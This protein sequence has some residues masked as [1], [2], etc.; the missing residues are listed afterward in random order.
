M[1]PA[2]PGVSP[3]IQEDARLAPRALGEA[4]QD[5]SDIR[6]LEVRVS[7]LATDVH[8]MS[9]ALARNRQRTEQ[10][11]V[12]DEINDSMGASLIPRKTQITPPH[13]HRHLH[14]RPAATAQARPPVAAA[15]AL[16]KGLRRSSVIANQLQSS[17]QACSCVACMLIRNTNAVCYMSVVVAAVSSPTCLGRWNRRWPLCSL[18]TRRLRRRQS[19]W[20]ANA[21]GESSLPCSLS[22]YRRGK[23]PRFPRGGSDTATGVPRAS[24]RSMRWRHPCLN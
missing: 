3:E 22:R 21:G 4:Q 8:T 2:G 9:R 23:S 13:S 11:K 16:R 7:E 5:K 19:A 10:M 24:R 17:E 6:A 15:V 20:L 12:A 14:N 1:G 18:P